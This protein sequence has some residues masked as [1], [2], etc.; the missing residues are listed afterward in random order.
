MH[1]GNSRLTIVSTYIFL[2]EQPNFNV[3]WK[4][5]EIALELQQQGC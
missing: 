5:V 3:S 4:S 2:T 1:S